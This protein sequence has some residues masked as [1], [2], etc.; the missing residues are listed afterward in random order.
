MSTAAGPASGKRRLEGLT[1]EYIQKLRER[2]AAKIAVDEHGCW[3]WQ[4]S[5]SA[6]GY[7]TVRVGPSSAQAHRITAEMFLPPW[8]PALDVD[9]LCRVRSCCNPL[10]VEPV[11]H[12]TNVQRS[13]GNGNA[14]KTH[15]AQGHEFSEGNTYRPPLQPTARQCIACQK[16]REANRTVTRRAARLAAQLADRPIEHAQEAAAA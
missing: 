13:I 15:C 5:L 4:G 10:H 2:M 9:H 12:K 1:P 8:D 7:G 16:A 11:E 14:A 3:I 6:G